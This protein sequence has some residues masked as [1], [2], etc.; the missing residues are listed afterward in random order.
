MEKVGKTDCE[1]NF[2]R[3]IFK[4]RKIT[5]ILDKIEINELYGENNGTSTK[6]YHR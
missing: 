6:L 1:A 2:P 3:K 5:P 4:K